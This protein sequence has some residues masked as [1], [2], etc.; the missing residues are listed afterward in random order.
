[1]TL[2]QIQIPD[3]V[4]ITVK[5]ES[6]TLVKVVDNLTP[7]G[8]TLFTLTA[9]ETGDAVIS[10]STLD[11]QLETEYGR[12]HLSPGDVMRMASDC[13]PLLMVERHWMSSD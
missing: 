8:T 3:R 9:I 1:M 7:P 2:P 5:T 6:G 12:R 13:G 11:G 10:I 4:R